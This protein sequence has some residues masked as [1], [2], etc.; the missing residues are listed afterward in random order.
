M[1]K[2]GE[3]SLRAA[4]GHEVEVEAVGT[5]PLVLHNGFRLYLNNVLFVPT[6]K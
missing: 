3:R 4:D 1:L 5:L 6:L 2:R